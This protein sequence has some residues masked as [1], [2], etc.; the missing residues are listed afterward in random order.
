MIEVEI[1]EILNGKWIQSAFLQ[2]TLHAFYRFT[3]K[4][5]LMNCVYNTN[6]RK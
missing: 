4:Q 5:L 3:N 2:C 6:K 1:L